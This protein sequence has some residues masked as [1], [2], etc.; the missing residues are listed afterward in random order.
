[1]NYSGA[2]VTAANIAMEKYRGSEAGGRRAP[3]SS[4]WA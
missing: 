1:M 2:D 3:L 4:W